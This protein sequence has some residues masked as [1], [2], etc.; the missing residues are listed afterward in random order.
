MEFVRLFEPLSISRMRIPNRI[1]MP[2]M[3]LFYAD[4]YS[5]TKRFKAF[6]RE[7]ARGGAG[8]IIMGPGAIDKVGSNPFMAGLFDDS[9]VAPIR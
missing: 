9:H 6:Y 4:Q 5:F 8:L 1:V 3:A 7:R 2:A